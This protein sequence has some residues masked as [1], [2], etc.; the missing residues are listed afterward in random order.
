MFERDSVKAKF[1]K[2]FDS[3]GSIYDSAVGKRM[4]FTSNIMLRELEIPE[5]P[6][7]LDIAC[8]TGISTFE[9][10]KKCKGH[11]TFYGVDLSDSM[12]EVARKNAVQQGYQAV[13]SQGD[14]ENLEYSD[15]MF[16]LA[17][18]NVAFHFFPDKEK[19]LS[20]MH[21][22]LKPG[23]QTALLFPGM[24]G[25]QEATDIF[26]KIA[27][28][29]PEYPGF[30]EAVNGFRGRLMSLEAALNLFL[31]SDFHVSDLYSRRSIG[32]VDPGIYIKDTPVYQDMWRSG[33]PPDAVSEIGEEM[34]VEFIKLS[35]SK[36]FKVSSVFII[37]VLKKRK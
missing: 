10:I 1:K 35:D 13:F 33:V 7:A 32:F 28:R 34:L 36:G 15:S 6:V 14:A 25:I 2:I 8:G 12:I 18:C 11:G 29:H 19:A 37:A 31:S 5:K 24:G 30:L 21:R 9:L 3:Q 20:E 26:L 16:D 22:I 4:I 17:I 27:G 23:G